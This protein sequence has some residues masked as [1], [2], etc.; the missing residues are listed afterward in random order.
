M[1]CPLHLLQRPTQ[2][3]FLPSAYSHP[4]NGRNLPAAAAT[5]ALLDTAV[6]VTLLVKV[7]GVPPVVVVAFPCVVA[8]AP[9]EAVP[10]E[11]PVP[12][13]PVVVVMMPLIPP[14]EVLGLVQFAVSVKKT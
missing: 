5:L 4:K 3:V 6:V 9:D 14:E 10:L 11:F 12:P 2:R 8:A 13:P 1:F 7:N